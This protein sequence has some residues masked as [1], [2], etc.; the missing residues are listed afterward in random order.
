MA[1]VVNKLAGAPKGN[2]KRGNVVSAFG[3]VLPPSSSSSSIGD[4]AASSE[5]TGKKVTKILRPL[6]SLLGTVTW[7]TKHKIGSVALEVKEGNNMYVQGILVYDAVSFSGIMVARDKKV[8]RPFLWTIDAGIGALVNENKN[9]EVYQWLYDLCTQKNAD[10]IGECIY[11]HF[12]NLYNNSDKKDKVKP[13]IVTAFENN[14]KA[15]KREIEYAAKE[16]RPVNED[17][18]KHTFVWKPDY[19]NLRFYNKDDGDKVNNKKSSAKQDAQDYEQEMANDRKSEE[20]GEGNTEM[21]NDVT[22]PPNSSGAAETKAPRAPKQQETEPVDPSK[23][24]CTIKVQFEHELKGDKWKNSVF[25]PKEFYNE[26]VNVKKKDG[27]QGRAPGPDKKFK[28]DELLSVLQKIEFKQNESY[29]PQ[30]E[31]NPC[32]IGH[33]VSGAAQLG[34]EDVSRLEVAED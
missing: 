34:R 4:G 6:K 17:E 9:V 13:L 19:P 33:Q 22:S 8:H 28:M 12:L 24:H 14:L 1:G 20:D 7:N 31:L 26:W 2:P 5:G 11:Q 18:I 30:F 3:R 29:Y 25:P 15:T 27:T 23:C 16:G 10:M 21:V 32:F